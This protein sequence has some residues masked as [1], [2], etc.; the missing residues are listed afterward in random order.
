[1]ADSASDGMETGGST[2]QAPCGR[3]RRGLTRIVNARVP[4]PVAYNGIWGF[5]GHMASTKTPTN[6]SG[7]PTGP[8]YRQT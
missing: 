2:A 5:G 1:M 7:L 6:L 4:K 8:A 3:K